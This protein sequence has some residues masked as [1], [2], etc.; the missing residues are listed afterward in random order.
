MN[1]KETEKMKARVKILQRQPALSLP[2]LF[3]Q[4]PPPAIS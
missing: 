1:K 2:P 3:G 4:F